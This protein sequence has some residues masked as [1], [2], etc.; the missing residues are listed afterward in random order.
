MW[1]GNKVHDRIDQQAFRRAI[2]AVLIV[3]GLNLIRRGLF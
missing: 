1:L 2:L 3:A